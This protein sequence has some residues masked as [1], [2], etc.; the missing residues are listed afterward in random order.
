MAKQEQL[1]DYEYAVAETS[2]QK[3]YERLLA[4]RPG[5]SDEANAREAFRRGIAF[6]RV[7]QEVLALGP[8]AVA[9]TDK[10]ADP[11]YDDGFAPNL[12]KNHPINLRS[13]E[14]G[15]EETL[16]MYDA[17]NKLRNSPHESEQEE[18]RKMWF[19]GDGVKPSI[20]EARNN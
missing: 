6:A 5:F 18:A 20:L 15:T 2:A 12:P 17:W 11:R 1:Q 16:A 7:A 9:Q 19:S 13:R 3:H 4:A 10:D 14:Y 8:E